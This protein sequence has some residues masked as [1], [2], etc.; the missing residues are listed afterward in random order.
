MKISALFPPSNYSY[1]FWW[2]CPKR[3]DFKGVEQDSPKMLG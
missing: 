1:S 2:G 3:L